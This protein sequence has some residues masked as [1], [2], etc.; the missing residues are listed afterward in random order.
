MNAAMLGCSLLL[1]LAMDRFGLKPPLAFGP[2][3]VAAALVLIVRSAEAADL[4]PALV[5]LG[6]GGGALNGATNT[7]AADLHEDEKQ[8]A[9]ALN[10]LGV[11]FGFGALTIPFA[12]GALM[13][14]LGMN[15]LLYSAAV[16]CVAVAVLALSLRF[17]EPKQRHSLPVREMPRFLTSPL[18]LAMALL[19]FFQSGAEFTLG[20]Y[21]STYLTQALGTTPQTGAWVLAAYWASLMVARVALSRIVLRIGPQR[22]LLSSTAVAAIGCAIVAAAQNV[23]VATVGLLIAGLALA[24]VYPTVLGLAGNYFSSHSGTVFGILFTVALTGGMT[25]PW[26]AG[27]LADAWTLRAVFVLVGLGFL[28]EFVLGTA[29]RRSA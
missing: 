15:R 25:I 1:G 14:A 20:G 6:I 11:F 5:L 27:Q 7:L 4:T 17:P 23:A 9:S 29:V 8:K 22:V 12:S 2:L 18:V 21:I 10:L 13:S 28:I 16:L 19:L 3:L 26:L 24:G